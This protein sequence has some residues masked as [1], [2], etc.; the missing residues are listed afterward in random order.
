MSIYKKGDR[1]LIDYY[2]PD[3]KRKREVVTIPGV[4][5]SRITRY[6]AEKALTIRKAEIA[7]GKFD[8]AKTQKPVL[9]DKLMAEYLEWAK[10]NHKAYERDIMASKPLLAFFG[11]KPIN[12]INLW[13]VEKYKALRRAQG[14]KPGTINKELGILRRMLNLA[15]E[16]KRVS[17]NPIQGM[18]LLPVPNFLP[19]T[20]R[21]SEFEILYRSAP[22]HFKPILLCAYLT[23]MRRSELRLLKW[24]D[25]DLTD[26]FIYVHEAKNNESRAIP[27]CD[28]LYDTL[29]EFKELKQNSNSEYVFTTPQG[30]P[31]TSKNAWRTAW[32]DAL[33]KA[34]I[35]KFRFHDLRHTFVSNLIVDEKEDYATVMAL[36]GHRDITVLKRYSHTRESAKRS[37]VSK[38]GKRVKINNMDTSMDTSI[39]EIRSSSPSTI[40]KL[41]K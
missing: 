39:R 22:S 26:R 17:N 21:D 38:L 19:R 35:A 3:G 7:Q 4:D 11:G 2:Q 1:W 37:A 8:I 28:V 41:L 25:V 24:E 40:H 18:K 30:K 15:L 14:R 23:G 36:S 5:P 29:K 13:L 20:L 12:N 9:F 31:Y 34:G 10:S 27:I 32:N 33:K 6:D 16:W